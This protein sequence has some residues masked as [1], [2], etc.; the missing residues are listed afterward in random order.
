MSDKQPGQIGIGLC[1][2]EVG[3]RWGVLSVPPTPLSA[4]QGLGHSGISP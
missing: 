2:R 4:W 3:A 1:G